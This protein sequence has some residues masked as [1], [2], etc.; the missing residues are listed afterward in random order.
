MNT[1][2]QIDRRDFAKLLGAAGLLATTGRITRAAE[3]NTA[4][5]A[6]APAASPRAPIAGTPAVFAPAADSATIVLPLN[7]PA[8]GWIEFGTSP[9]NLD[10]RSDGDALGF[11]PHDDRVLK[12]RLRGLA[13]GT[14]YWWRAA[15][16][17][18]APAAASAHSSNP[19]KEPTP[20]YT[21]TYSFATLAPAAAET[22]FVV[23]NDTHN[24]K[25]TLARLAGL[26]SGTD[27]TT[28]PD[29][30][31]W[32]GDIAA[33][34]NNETALIPQ[35]YV[36]PAGVVD[37]AKGPPVFLA[38]GNHDS[39]GLWANK[40]LDY[41]DFPVARETDAPRPYY[42]FRSGPLAAIVL[43]TGEDKPDRH[44][45]FRGLVAFE[46]LIAEQARWLEKII[47]RPDIKNAPVKIV[48]CHLPLRW[49][50]ETPQ[51]YFATPAGFDRFSKRGRDAWHASLVKWG[52]RAVISA[53]VHRWTHI[54]ATAVFPYAQI[55][56]GGADS[57]TA[58]LLRARVTAS[59]IKLTACDL[60]GRETAAV[61][62]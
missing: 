40:V 43:E 1:N 22:N 7:A 25:D 19:P 14:R 34:N 56:G 13:P 52:A 44:P 59:E 29:F 41:V 54:P 61:T 16:V 8:R 35:Y 38:R 10:Q 31:F 27:A 23:W 57:A 2:A 28:R 47:E 49:I 6:K 4:P 42:A 46:P 58:R 51:D 11:T 45:S 24:H 20:V 39:R 12:I 50:D 53:H 15:C 9:G 32:N 17:A 18:L 26:T 5:S 55:T 37:L 62:L 21:A 60:T 36:H 48:F 3:T 33:S 30:L